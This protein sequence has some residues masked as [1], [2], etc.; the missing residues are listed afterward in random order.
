M[1]NLKNVDPEFYAYLQQNDKKLLDFD[2]DDEDDGENLSSGD[3][4]E[5]RHIP[6]EDLEVRII[7]YTFY[8]YLKAF[9]IVFLFADSK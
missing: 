9:I 5:S 4:N 8:Q 1:Q 2:L 7:K 6:N 3:E